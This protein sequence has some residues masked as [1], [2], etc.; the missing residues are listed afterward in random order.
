MK[1]MLEKVAAA[2]RLS[3]PD[4]RALAARIGRLDD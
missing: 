1:R 2:S 4:R 3:D